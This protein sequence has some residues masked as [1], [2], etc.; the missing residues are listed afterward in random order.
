LNKPEVYAIGADNAVWVN[1]GSGWVSLGGYAEQVSAGLDAAGN[2]FV[3]AIGLNDGLW[4]DHGAGW[5]SLG[6]YVTE[7]CAPDVG[8]GLP[9]DLAYAVAKGHGCLLHSG[10]TFTTLGGTIE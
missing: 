6:G 2:P 10:T 7:I 3:F 8:V 9:G 5:V 1:D 4:S